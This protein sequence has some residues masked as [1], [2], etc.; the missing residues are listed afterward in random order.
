MCVYIYI[1]IL[2]YIYD[3][4]DYI[5]IIL[6]L[7]LNHPHMFMLNLESREDHHRTMIHSSFDAWNDTILWWSET[8]SKVKSQSFLCFIFIVYGHKPLWD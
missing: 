4:N 2:I 7:S 3:S 5:L 1:Y 8:I 6:S